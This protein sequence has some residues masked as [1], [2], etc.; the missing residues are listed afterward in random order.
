MNYS[1]NFTKALQAYQ[2]APEKTGIFDS[3]FWTMIIE[4]VCEH[5]RTN[6]TIDA[7]LRDAGSFF[8]YG[9]CKEFFSE[10][11]S[12]VCCIE[13][14]PAKNSPLQLFSFSSWLKDQVD[15]IRQCDKRDTLVK[16]LRTNQI[17][18][19][20]V[21]REIQSLRNQRN[22][23]L[24]ELIDASQSP[25]AQTD[26]SRLFVE[27]SFI[28]EAQL[29]GIRVKK[30]ISKGTFF[31]VD[32]K[33]E[34]AQRENRLSKA[35]DQLKAF[36]DCY[37]PNELITEIRHITTSLSDLLQKITDIEQV[38][39]KN[40]TDIELLEK[41]Q[42]E[43]S[44]IEF[45]NKVRE[46][47]EHI[48]DLTR[49]SAKRMHLENSPILIPEKRFLSYSKIIDC[50]NRILEFDPRIFKNDRVAFLGKPQV[51]LVPGSGNALYDW[52]NNLIVIPLSCTSDNP[53]ASISTGMI[54]YRLDMDEDKVLLNSYNQLPE[55]KTIRSSIQLKAQLVKDYTTWMT[56]EYM[57]YR[58][59]P[60]S[61]KE[62][63]EHEIGPSKNDIFIPPAY[64]PFN[65]SGAE[66]NKLIKSIDERIIQKGLEEAETQDLW[67]GSILFHLQ[68]NYQRAY[69]LLVVL[70]KRNVS[71]PMVFYNFGQ[72][73][74]K[75]YARS[76][77]IKGFS[78]F[79]NRIPQCWWTR[80]AG[81]HLRNIQSSGT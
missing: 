44:P 49:L 67:I 31:S 23:K 41:S 9:V 80:V 71:N 35:S 46:E 57:G 54:E 37:P 26:L 34:N 51:V 19:S 5:V 75:L 68:G 13:D 20:K 66:F 73:A 2:E 27:L 74:S 25:N 14:T 63:F 81:D 42:A 52:K 30:A 8:D 79:M 24:T 48:R 77:A 3:P 22:A 47:L 72:V 70:L 59:L 64:Q 60:K 10:P 50:L 61:V 12:Q 65:F 17:Q 53:M 36:L 33:R 4:N 43:L 7:F 29:D 69:D 45:E 39:E 16:E 56:S 11:Q 1:E 6:G 15:K 32:Q 58:V 76:N 62:W 18:L 78:E 55:T 38:L 21:H 40:Q 28:D